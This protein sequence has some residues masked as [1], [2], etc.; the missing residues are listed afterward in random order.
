MSSYVYEQRL[1]LEKTGPA[2]LCI[3]CA[4]VFYIVY[5][6]PAGMY[7]DKVNTRLPSGKEAARLA[8]SK[9]IALTDVGTN[10][11]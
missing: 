7:K 5:S 4:A 3:C 10:A 2:V 11:H 6:L 1:P 9:D 8:D